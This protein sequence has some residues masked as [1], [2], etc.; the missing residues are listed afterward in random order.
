MIGFSI[1]LPSNGNGVFAV[2][3]IEDEIYRSSS[4]YRLW[5]YTRESLA[6]IRQETNDLASQRVRA[7]F[8]R[9]R[10]VQNGH[11]GDANGGG[12]EGAAADGEVEIETLTVEEEL[13]T[14]EWG[15]SK[16][17]AMGE[18]MNPRIPSHVVVSS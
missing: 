4:Q 8:R 16:I 1:S 17:V 6:R 7:A 3:M 10:S 9:A 5:S 11:V 12:V 14:V 13:K 18:M 2:T 15:C